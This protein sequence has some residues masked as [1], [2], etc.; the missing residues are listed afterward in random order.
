MS[1]VVIEVLKEAAKAAIPLII[2]EA[3]KDDNKKSGRHSKHKNR[4]PDYK[5]NKRR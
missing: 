4:R 3:F 1:P 2:K 5:N